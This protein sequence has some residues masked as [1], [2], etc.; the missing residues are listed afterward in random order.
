MAKKKLQR[1]VEGHMMKGRGRSEDAEAPTDGVTTEAD[2]L[3]DAGE[4]EVEGQGVR[5]RGA[6]A[7]EVEGHGMVK[8]KAPATEVQGHATVRVKATDEQAP[9]ETTSQAD[10]NREGDGPDVEGHLAR[11]KA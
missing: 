3:R 4:P 10:D 11:G 2:E 5:G 1:D 7:A 9:S 8:G 6:P